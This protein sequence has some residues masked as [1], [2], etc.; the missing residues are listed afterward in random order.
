MGLSS[1]RAR[2]QSGARAAVEL[3]PW[4]A[5]YLDTYARAL[6]A[7]GRCEEAVRQQQRAMDV[8]AERATPD[9]REELRR[10][11]GATQAGCAAASSK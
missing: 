8:A 5:E 6:L 1:S 3:A 4:N 9:Q 2:A 11:I 10:R 7:A